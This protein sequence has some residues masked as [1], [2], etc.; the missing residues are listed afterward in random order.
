MRCRFTLAVLALALLVTGCRGGLDVYADASKPGAPMTRDQLGANLALYFEDSSTPALR[1]KLERDGIGLLRWPGGSLA[2]TYDW[3]KNEY[4]VPNGKLCD[5]IYANPEVDFDQFM[6]Q[7]VQ[8]ANFDLNITVNYGS[9]AGC[10]GG[11]SAAEAADWVKYSNIDHHYNVKYWTIG[12]EQYFNEKNPTTVD[13][14]DPPHDPVEY[15]KRV[16]DEF[17]PQMKAVDPTIQIGVDVTAGTQTGDN[18]APNWDSVVLANAKYDFVEFHYYPDIYDDDR[19]LR[20][21]P[22]ALASY[23]ATL[24]RELA[25]AGHAD[26]PI[27]L[28]EFDDDTNGG[29][30]TVSIVDALFVGMVIGEVTKAGIPMASV[31]EGVADCPHD[32]RSSASTYGWQHYGSFGMFSSTEEYDQ[33]PTDDLTAFPKARAFQLARLFVVPGERPLETTSM[34]PSI[35][36]YGATHGNGGFAF[37]LFNLDRNR[38][39]HLR[40]GVE[41]AQAKLFNAVTATYGKEQYD[42]SRVGQWVGPSSHYL[43]V[44]GSTA[45]VRLPPWSMTVLTLTPIRP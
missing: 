29:K 40:V 8:P 27:Y 32:D 14:N 41:H 3:Q 33:C 4:F 11:G 15:A 42:E 37:M 18:V 30:Q 31:Y 35:R 9:N 17:Y 12:N 39:A 1:D 22:E 2:D 10:T 5:P 25:A 34:S 44:V 19:M 28:G 7:M 20:T 23:I 38:A 13:L 36:A 6:Q 16:A 26:T 21:A 45:T 24:R 43:G